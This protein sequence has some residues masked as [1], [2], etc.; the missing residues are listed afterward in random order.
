VLG[1]KPC[2]A[3]GG[4]VLRSPPKELTA[5]LGDGQLETSRDGTE[6]RFCTPNETQLTVSLIEGENG[7]QVD[8]VSGGRE[9]TVLDGDR[10]VGPCRATAG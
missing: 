6:F 10:D 7:W 2:R 5:E 1:G 4:R 9:V 8:L 3:D